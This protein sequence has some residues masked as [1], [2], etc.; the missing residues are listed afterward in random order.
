MPALPGLAQ[1]LLAWAGDAAG[2][3]RRA[4][5]RRSAGDGWAAARRSAAWAGRWVGL[6]PVPGEPARRV[7]AEAATAVRRGGAE[8]LATSSV[9]V[10]PLQEDALRG[11]DHVWRVDARRAGRVLRP[12]ARR[13]G[14]VVPRVAA[15][16][17]A[18]ALVGWFAPG[19][20]LST[21]AGVATVPANPFPPLAQRSVVLAADGS[22]LGVVAGRANRR[23]VA[24]G[25][26]PPL[27]RRLVVLSED[28]RFY[29]HKGWD[30]SAILRAAVADVRGRG[31]TQ[32]ASTISQQL[33]KQNLVG[34]QRSAMRKVRELV[35][36]VA[37][38]R[39]STKS[40]LLGRYL[41]QVYFG[42][43]AYG[44]AAA[45]E[46]Y[47]GTTVGRLRPEQAALLA[48]VIRSPS[49]LNPWRDPDSV[50][51]RR[52]E[53]LRAAAGAGDLT[54]ADA[55]RAAT[56]PLGLLPAPA[57]P[58]V[59]DPDLVGAVQAEI[60]SRPELGATPAERLGRFESGGW[61]VQTTL[62]PAVQAAAGRAARSAAA[63]AGA[64]GAAVAVVEPGTGRVR[65]LYS[66]RPPG[67][68]QLDL[69]SSG[70][71]QPGS[72][73]KPLAAIAALEGGLDPAQPLEGQSGR[74]YDLDPEDWQV[75]NFDDADYPAPDLRGAL[76]KS[77][78]S[79]FAQLGV[80]VGGAKVAG[81]A[82]RLGVD[83]DAA[84]GPPPERGPALALGGTSRGVTPLELAAAYAA[85]ADEGVY[86]RPTLIERIV[87][88]EG[89]EVLRRAPD[90]RPAVDPAVNDLVRSMLQDVVRSGTGT[91]AALPGWQPFGKTG[92]SQDRA[93]AWFVGAV[94]TAAGAVWVGDPRTRVPMPTA[95]G[96]TVAAPAWRDVM[97]VAVRDQPP[98]TFPAG[99]PLPPP[100]APLPLPVGH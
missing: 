50:R 82:G 88:P 73:F 34:G 6:V 76:V 95:T 49:R 10:R 2:L 96:G 9:A 84:L 92:T 38:E 66:A 75:R 87:D 15:V 99:P 3:F 55:A 80:A 32:G 43:G 30:Q 28:R 83:V 98:R 59:I 4:A 56:T 18:L 29:Q 40:E 12:V 53:L 35:L 37:V 46:T 91:A 8:W 13:C 94:P 78:N 77:I 21:T 19:P 86:V 33:V 22:P 14:R 79:A 62:D 70:R 68:D 74:T 39:E 67:L 45:A 51:E 7:A 97:E 69:A 58:P 11:W 81:V 36:S 25:D 61:S 52:D 54:P 72:A 27:V 63:G 85:I 48:V 26:V 20:L 17:V 47:F 5:S 65:A 41:N 16:A 93:D 100:P 90:P 89:R 24:L 71:R 64:P 57:R 23:V 31:S 44:I 60:A 42:S 1:V